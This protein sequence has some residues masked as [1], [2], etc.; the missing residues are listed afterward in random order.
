MQIDHNLAGMGHIHLSDIKFRPPVLKNKFSQ[1][2]TSG[3]IQIIR[4]LAM[5]SGVIIDQPQTLPTSPIELWCASLSG[6]E[7]TTLQ[8]QSTCELEGDT[9][10]EG[11]QND[12]ER[13]L[14]RFAQAED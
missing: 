11:I 5:S 7:R 6:Y 9:S 14:K 1:L 12:K 3:A 10:A 13:H 4:E 2:H 8:K